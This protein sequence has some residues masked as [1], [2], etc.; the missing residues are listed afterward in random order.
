MLEGEYITL[1][2]EKQETAARDVFEFV[3][4]ESER[5][6]AALGFS[7][8]QNIK[9]Y[10]YDRQSTLQTKKYGLIVLLLNLDWYVGDNRGADILLVSP[11]DPGAHS[12]ESIKYETSVHELV[13]AYNYILNKNMTYWLDNGIAGYLAGQTPYPNFVSW[14]NSIPSLTQTRTSN[15]ITFSS[16]GGYPFSY[17]YVEFLDEAYGWD[18]VLVLAETDSFEKAFGKSENEIYG[19]WLVF[20]EGRWSY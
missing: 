9:M 7:E 4:A 19:E 5:I 1:F 18:S 16:F 2:Y 14:Y 12:Y 6:A 3:N 15:P 20:L 13:H 10:L 11:T 17:T 8:P